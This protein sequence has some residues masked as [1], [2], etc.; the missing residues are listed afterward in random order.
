MAVYN[1]PSSN[2]SIFNPSLF[3]TS[4]TT[5]FPET[6]SLSLAN[7]QLNTQYNRSI[8]DTLQVTQLVSFSVL[9]FRKGANYN[10]T[11]MYF[12]GTSSTSN[13]YLSVATNG[14][15]TSFG[16]Q[17]VL[18]YYPGAARTGECRFGVQFP[19]SGVIGNLDF[20]GLGAIDSNGF[21]IG[22]NPNNGNF[23]FIYWTSG[24]SQIVQITITTAATTGGNLALTLNGVIYTVALTNASTDKNF[25]GFQIANNAGSG[26]TGWVVDAY[27]DGSGN[28]YVDFVS[29]YPGPLTG[30]YSVTAGGTGIVAT[31]STI[32]VGV[33]PTF[34]YVNE[35][36]F[37]GDVS[38]S[39]SMTKTN[40]NSYA[41]RYAYNG[42]WVCN[43]CAYSGSQA[44]VLHSLVLN[45]VLVSPAMLMM[46]FCQRTGSSNTQINAGAFSIYYEDR[47]QQNS[48]LRNFS[49]AD[50]S[51][52]N[53]VNTPVMLN[54]LRSQ[55]NGWVNH[56]TAT[57]VSMQGY[58]SN[59]TKDMQF[60]LFTQAFALGAGTTANYPSMT[61][62]DANSG[63]LSG[64]PTTCTTITTIGIKILSNIFC[65]PQVNVQLTLPLGSIAGP[66][67]INIPAAASFY[68]STFV[69]LYGFI[70]GAAGTASIQFVAWENL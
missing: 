2:L 13:G 24:R 68:Y 65:S 33:T 42:N 1:P 67:G 47:I 52:P 7:V 43:L 19:T 37:N 48:V 69:G 15:G 45:T 64:S 70:S 29:I 18:S 4:T 20:I 21:G 61:L 28:Y 8:Y 58:N 32:T 57:A 41:L 17:S 3:G 44:I 49:N 60:F 22:H 5:S 50:T 66:P 10:M 34:T 56:S 46:C 36:A 62:Y 25:S 55:I 54:K 63:M 30:T 6:A 53:G 40:W 11:P 31:I 38:Y 26:Y 14:A 9:D 23:A 27:T 39:Q 12:T 59:A 16:M 51:V 35:S